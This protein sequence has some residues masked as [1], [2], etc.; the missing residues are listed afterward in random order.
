MFATP[1][2]NNRWRANLSQRGR[3]SPTHVKKIVW[4]FQGFRAPSLQGFSFRLKFGANQT[5]MV[6][7][8]FQ[9]HR[10][11]TVFWQ[12]QWTGGLNGPDFFCLPTIYRLTQPENQTKIK[13]IKPG[14]KR[15]L[16]DPYKV[17]IRRLGAG[18]R[19]FVLSR[20]Q[21][22]NSSSREDELKV[23]STFSRFLIS[24]ELPLVINQNHTIIAQQYPF[25][26]TY[27]PRYEI[28]IFPSAVSVPFA[29]I[30]SL[31]VPELNAPKNAYLATEGSLSR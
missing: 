14:F 18:N 28:Y 30:I 26:S 12:G 23:S 7:K 3:R 20:V 29:A 5:E 15:K 21:T 25:M 17:C 6:A 1:L 11:Q 31:P 8:P 19:S 2:H 24:C 22:N 10:F 9:N 13:T 16:L 27:R 4:V